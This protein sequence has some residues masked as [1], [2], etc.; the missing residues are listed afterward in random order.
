[1]GFIAGA[2]LTGATN[3]Y[4]FFSNIASGTGRWNFYAA[5]SAANYF[6]GSTFI[7]GLLGG[8][9]KF[10]IG[11][12]LPTAGTGSYANRVVATIP[13]GATGGA[14]GFDTA[15]ST[16]AAAF[17]CASLTHYNASQATIGAT[18][19]VT[20]QAG[21][22]V[23]NTLT[24]AT[25]NFGFRSDIAAA[26]GRWNFYTAGTAANYFAGNTGV[27]TTSLTA[28]FNA[29]DTS[30]FSA[31]RNVADFK[32]NRGFSN[33]PDGIRIGFT[34]DN[35]TR[36][37]HDYGAFVFQN[38]TAQANGGAAYF[39]ARVG[40]AATTGDIGTSVNTFLRAYASGVSTVANVSL[41]TN[42]IERL[43]VNNAGNVLI[44]TTTNTNS[45]R[46]IVNGTIS[47]TVSAVQYL[48]ASQFDVGNAPN[49][50]PLNQYL[51]TMAYQDANAITA[52]TVVYRTAGVLSEFSIGNAG[53]TRTVTW[54]NGSAQA[55]TLD[56]N[57]TITFSFAGCPVGNYQ[58]KIV[59]DGTG[60]RAITWSTATPST[61]RWLGISGAPT[62]NTAANSLSFANFYWDGT[63]SYG[64]LARVNSV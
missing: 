21:F 36:G 29:A 16:Q 7:G 48:V 63:N 20:N 15:L 56:Q 30:S 60:G 4:G 45:S 32:S 41:V 39:E 14:T 10:A 54:S 18:S 1:M 12:T 9:T 26:T 57:T 22:F 61:T 46:L 55:V 6:E 8:D 44:G 51:G 38:D 3:N 17:T 5:G 62:L 25:N 24:G 27:G 19:A 40:G 47:E 2:N 11:G 34:A 33:N 52:G 28:R 50:I 42:N 35:G 53:A 49:Q 37:T 31:I 64:T 59:Q 13:S 23:Q 43:S 58:L